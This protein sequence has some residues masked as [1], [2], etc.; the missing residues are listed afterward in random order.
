MEMDYWVSIPKVELHAHLNG[1]V[2]DSTLLY[3]SL[4]VSL[5]FA[6]F[7]MIFYKFVIIMLHISFPILNVLVFVLNYR[8]LAKELGEKGIILF[9]DVEHVILKSTYTLIDFMLVF[10][11][12][13]MLVVV[14]IVILVCR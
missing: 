2:R 7:L 9:S 10:G 14:I 8:E 1:S 12:F 5:H 13:L 11:F 4:T 6:P 3:L